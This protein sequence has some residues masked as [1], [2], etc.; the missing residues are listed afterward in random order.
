MAEYRLSPAAQR[1]L[2]SIF[3]HT[4]SEWGLPHALRYTSMIQ[5][6]CATLA[7]APQ[8]AQSC[9][10]IRPGYRRKRIERH[11]LYFQPKPYGIAVMRIL[12]ERMDASRHL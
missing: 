2:D 11:M 3:D 10:N 9:E 7:D 4:V 12:H 5:A 1:D 8:Q 6:A